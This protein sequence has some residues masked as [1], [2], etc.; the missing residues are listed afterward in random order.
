MK[1]IPFKIQLLAVMFVIGAAFFGFQAQVRSA[2][3]GKEQAAAPSQSFN[4]A[5]VDVQALLTQS[6]AAKNIQEQLNVQRGEFKKEIGAIDK[7]LKDQQQAL[8]K[9]NGKGTEEEFNK[10]KSELEKSVMDARQTVQK[11]RNALDVAAGTALEKLRGEITKVVAS[12]SDKNKYD[13]VIS[14]QNVVLAVKSMDITEEVMKE[15]N[16]NV[17]KI[18]LKVETN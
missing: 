12:L 13:I 1:K 11:R 9:S 8:I 2:A 16:S 6:A 17:T 15:L 18:D 5:V 10:K 7:K 3:D 4:M 14:R